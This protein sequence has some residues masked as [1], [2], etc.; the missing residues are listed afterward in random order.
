MI[1]EY[2]TTLPPTVPNWQWSSLK[3]RAQ[4]CMKVI[5]DC[6]DQWPKV[7]KNENKSEQSPRWTV[8]KKW[9]KF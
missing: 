5:T 3:P 4:L 9:I 8:L 7:D 6:D 1:P 2:N